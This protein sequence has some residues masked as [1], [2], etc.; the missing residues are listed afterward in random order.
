MGP[1][2]TLKHASIVVR[3]GRVGGREGEKERQARGR[4][5]VGGRE[6]GRERR[7]D[8]KEKDKGWEGGRVACLIFLS[9]SLPSG[10]KLHLSGSKIRCIEE[11]GKNY[12][13]EEGASDIP[14]AITPH[15]HH[16]QQVA[17]P[18]YTTPANT[19]MMVSPNCTVSSEVP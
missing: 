18:T 17:P 5:R 8:R 14:P 7:R 2:P 9:P 1:L 11:T 19:L 6:R 13:L 12:T 4:E 10:A 16:T 15:Y 3:R